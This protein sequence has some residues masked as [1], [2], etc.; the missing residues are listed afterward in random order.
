MIYRQWSEAN[1]KQ[2][3]ALRFNCQ[4]NSHREIFCQSRFELI[5]KTIITTFYTDHARAIVEARRIWTT[6]HINLTVGAGEARGTRTR[7]ATETRVVT[8]ST[9]ATRSVVGTKFQIYT[10]IMFDV[11]ENRQKNIKRD[12]RTNAIKV[13][14]MYTCTR[15]VH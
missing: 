3:K 9:V 2:A 5:D 8:R 12:K 14:L 4:E 15:K 10:S 1:D 6:V 13:Q 7:V 11:S